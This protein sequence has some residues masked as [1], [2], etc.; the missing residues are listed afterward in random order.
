[1]EPYAKD[2]NG[3]PANAINGAISGLFFS[4]RLFN[5]VMS[6]TSPFGDR[7]FR[8]E[9]PFLLDDSKHTMYF[10]D[11]Y[12]NTALH[13]VT[14]VVCIR[15]SPTDIYCSTRLIRLN[16]AT[17]PFIRYY[18]PS[19]NLPDGGQEYLSTRFLVY[20]VFYAGSVDINR[21]PLDPIQ[22]TGMGTSR[23]GGLPNNK[24][25]EICN[26]YPV[27][28]PGSATEKGSEECHYTDPRE[29]TIVLCNSLTDVKKE[30]G[31]LWPDA[32]DTV[33]HLVNQTCEMME[34]DFGVADAQQRS[35]ERMDNAMAVLQREIEKC[36][37]VEI[38]A[39]AEDLRQVVSSFKMQRKVVM[40]LLN[41]KSQ[42]IDGAGYGVFANEVHLPESLM[43]RMPH[44]V[45]LTAGSI[46]DMPKYKKMLDDFSQKM[47]PFEILTLFFCLEESS[48]SKYG[49]Y[50]DVLPK[51]FDTPAADGIQLLVALAMKAGVEVSDRH[52]KALEEAAQP[53]T[54]YASDEGPSWSLRTN[55][56]IL[57]MPKAELK[58]WKDYVYAEDN[59]RRRL[60]TRYQE[61]DS[62]DEDEQKDNEDS[63]RERRE[64]EALRKMLVELAMS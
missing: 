14:I 48:S 55:M 6:G 42:E 46:A 50:L 53:S 45:L 37:D 38:L 19:K 62:D 24:Y 33:C 63:K 23:I 56:Q 52:V 13:Y 7:R 27:A 61:K 57:L 51:K 32:V 25:C 1:M 54:I 41:K 31:D 60:R 29:S 22:A 30:L 10:A 58:K 35:A 3:Q 15:D 39:F 34:N 59:R 11:F 49:P 12:C 16:P 47:A 44:S 9:A 18:P 26:L 21:R 28:K 17:N 2:N 64:R 36:Q 8:I 20:E 40:D 5:G 4:A 43:I